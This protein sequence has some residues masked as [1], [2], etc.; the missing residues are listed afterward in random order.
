MQRSATVVPTAKR[1]FME[2]RNG[3]RKKPIAVMARGRVLRWQPHCTNASA[4]ATT[5]AM[6]TKIRPSIAQSASHALRRLAGDRAF[7][8]GAKKEETADTMAAAKL[9][10]LSVP[11][12]LLPSPSLPPSLPLGQP[13]LVKASPTT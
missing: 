2:R 13:W 3:K 8:M 7:R 11:L 1:R 5:K 6:A 9:L 4:T 12:L 10:L